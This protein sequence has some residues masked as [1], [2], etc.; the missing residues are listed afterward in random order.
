M[1]PYELVAVAELDI[2]GLEYNLLLE[3][4][5][6]TELVYIAPEKITGPEPEKSRYEERFTTSCARLNALLVQCQRRNL[7]P[8]LAVRLN[9]A[10]WVDGEVN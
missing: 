6:L 1:N 8:E 10:A 3:L 4:R 5:E 7:V 9:A 2:T